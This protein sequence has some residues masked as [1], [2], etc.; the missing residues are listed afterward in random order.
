MLLCD[1]YS[2]CLLFAPFYYELFFS[3]FPISN[4]FCLP[5]FCHY[6]MKY[7]FII[8]RLPWD[9]LQTYFDILA[10]MLK[11]QKFNGICIVLSLLVV[12]FEVYFACRHICAQKL[13]VIYLGL[14]SISL[15]SKHNLKMN[16]STTFQIHISLSN[17]MNLS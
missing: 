17:F 16:T 9:Q 2:S 14:F 12:S 10:T 8:F 3:S 13:F 7:R 1:W 5:F 4:V 11:A 6:L 15:S